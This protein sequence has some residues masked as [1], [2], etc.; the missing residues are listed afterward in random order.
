MVIDL[1]HRTQPS[2]PGIHSQIERRRKDCKQLKNIADGANNKK[3]VCKSKF[4]I[5]SRQD[6]KRSPILKGTKHEVDQARCVPCEKVYTNKAQLKSHNNLAH[7]YDLQTCKLCGKELRNKTALRKHVTSVHLVKTVACKDCNKEFKN[8]FLLK[9][10]VKYFH[11]RSNDCMCYVCGKKYK[12][13]YALQRHMKKVCLGKKAKSQ[14]KKH[15]RDG[16]QEDLE[17]QYCKECDKTFETRNYFRRHYSLTHEW[18][19]TACH[20]CSLLYKSVDR[21]RR[22]YK[23]V[24]TVAK[25]DL[26]VLAPRPKRNR[27]QQTVFK[28]KRVTCNDCGNTY[29]STRK[30]KHRKTCKGI[31]TNMDVQKLENEKEDLSSILSRYCKESVNPDHASPTDKIESSP[32]ILDTKQTKEELA[33]QLGLTKIVSQNLTRDQLLEA[34]QEAILSEPEELATFGEVPVVSENAYLPSNDEE[35]KDKTE[36]FEVDRPQSAKEIEIKNMETV[37][38][39]R[40]TESGSLITPIDLSKENGKDKESIFTTE[41]SKNDS[42]DGPGVRCVSEGNNDNTGILVTQPNA[43]RERRDKS[44]YERSLRKHCKKRFNGEVNLLKD[45]KQKPGQRDKEKKR[46][47][48][49][50]CDESFSNQKIMAKHMHKQHKNDRKLICDFCSKIYKRQGPPEHHLQS[51]H[52]V[53]KATPSPVETNLCKFCSKSFA[54]E[55]ILKN[56]NNNIHGSKNHIVC[57]QCGK[58][59]KYKELLSNHIRNVHDRTNQQCP[60]CKK[61]CKNKV[62]LDRHMHHNHS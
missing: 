15:V 25:G 52:G 51:D 7:K 42:Q 30:S 23:V 47:E 32:H 33:E 14:R 62:A 40:T 8:G 49:N 26:E 44:K 13:D 27:I 37:E 55:K 4:Q 3:N 35:R 54:T 11:E 6:M 2:W 46:H 19:P 38:K 36:P 29:D 12:N 5:L 41:T 9:N 20:L 22:H 31:T 59:F 10:H 53:E 1:L 34:L 28:G 17:S 45:T 57:P 16:L 50:H 24:H 39:E 60:E 21:L 56:H 61:I 18:E 58:S 43:K 48:C